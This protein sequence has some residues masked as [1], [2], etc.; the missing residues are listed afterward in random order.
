[1]CGATLFDE[2]GDISRLL[3]RECHI[4]ETYDN[5]LCIVI[6]FSRYFHIKLKQNYSFKYVA[7]LLNAVFF[8]L[9]TLFTD[10]N[11]K[12][13]I[14]LCKY[15][16]NTLHEKVYSDGKKAYFSHSCDFQIPIL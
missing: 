7:N 15:I 8:Y 4:I 9:M 10:K 14:F 16:S 2:I 6:Q 5:K 1:M 11:L 13:H 3:N 12:I